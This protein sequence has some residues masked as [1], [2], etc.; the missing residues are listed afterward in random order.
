MCGIIGEIQKTNPVNVDQFDALRDLLFHRGPDGAGTELLHDSRI[1]LGHRRLSIIDLTENAKQPMC[2]EDGSIWITFN[3]EIYNFQELKAELSQHTFKSNSDT[4]VLI[5]GYEQWG[6]EKLLEK[7]K[8]MFA[9]GIWDDKKQ[10]L[11]FARDRFGIKPF[12]YQHSQNHFIFAS[13]VKCIAHQKDFSKNINQ[14]AL[15]DYFNYSYIPY[16]LTIWDGVYKLP[17]A[18]YGVLDFKTFELQLTKYWDL[19]LGNSIVKNDVAIEKAHELIDNAT[20]Q[21]LISDVPIGLFLSGGYDSTTLLM[22][23][24]D[25]GYKPDVFTIG[26]PGHENDETNQAKAIAKHFGVK[27]FIEDIPLG[28]NVVDLLQELSVFYDEP[29]AGNS[30]INNHLIAKTTVKHAKVAFSGEGADEVFGGYKWH[31]KIEKYYEQGT[32]KR[33]LRNWRLGIFDSKTEFLK[34]YNRSM[35]GVLEE[36][37]KCHVVNQ[38][39][40]QKMNLRELWHF[41]EFY[42]GNLTDKV[43]QAQNIDTHTFIPNHCL[44]RADL[45]SMANSLEVRVPF[46]DHEIYEYVFSL[47]RSVYMKKGS[48]KFLL[49]EK[50]K[51]RI[52]DSVLNMPKKGFSFH[53]SEN[54]FQKEFDRILENGLVVKYGILNK[55][56]K[57]KIELSENFKFHLVN[58]EFWLKNHFE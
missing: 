48:K 57:Q 21:H 6:I 2:N 50:L 10:Q 15:A 35:L 47:N 45:S 34:L 42:N 39:L 37:S 55:V 26:F 32:V 40:T 20:R 58:L 4:E 27:H 24:L 8:G 38:E 41:E 51:N 19:S 16:P 46:L 33:H 25:L 12:V 14:D 22:K 17:P 56:G 28:V 53:F 31:R 11:V 7:V 30:M 52:P 44:H 13:E 18:H 43:K 49:E 54:N 9:F 36:N 5:H 3:G 29:F 1:A 23:M